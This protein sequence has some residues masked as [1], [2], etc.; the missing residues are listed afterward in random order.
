[1]R[2]RALAIVPTDF[3]NRRDIDLFVL[4]LG[5][6]PAMLQ[7][8]RDGSFRD[9]SDTLR[10]PSATDY[11]SVAAADANKD[12]FVDV[13]LGRSGSPG[14]LGL[15]DGIG[16]FSWTEAP[17]STAG[18]VSAQFSD[19]DMDGLLDSFVLGAEA[20]VLLRNLG[21]TW[22]DVTAAALGPVATIPGHHSGRWR[23]ATS[24]AM[25]I[26]TWWSRRARLRVWRNDGG[27]TNRPS[28]SPRG[29]GQQPERGRRS[30]RDAGG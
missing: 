8:A 17:A 7:N 29:P 4:S 25:V 14:V 24:T 11:T 22:S 18:A 5:G 20:P 28:R 9:V 27:G 21:A 30:N 23:L 26:R 13:F 1:M 19:Y 15:S 2:R 10:L 3:D 12:G 6:P 16:G